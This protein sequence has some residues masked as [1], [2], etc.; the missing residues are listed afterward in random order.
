MQRLLVV[1][2]AVLCG[3]SAGVLPGQVGF[4][5]VNS[6]LGLITGIKFDLDTM[7]HPVFRGQA[8]GFL[9]IPFAQPPTGNLRFQVF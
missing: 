7:H 1:I 4:V 6:K 3:R 5:D 9:G 2:V 8:D